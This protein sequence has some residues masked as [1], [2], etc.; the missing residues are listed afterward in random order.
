MVQLALQLDGVARRRAHI[1]ASPLGEEEL[2][3]L[4]EEN[5]EESGR[6]VAAGESLPWNGGV[7]AINNLIRL[8]ALRY[9]YRVLSRAIAEMASR[10]FGDQFPADVIGVERD[11]AIGSG[12]KNRHNFLIRAAAD[13][14]DHPR[15]IFVDVVELQLKHHFFGADFATNI[16]FELDGFAQLRPQQLISGAF[17]LQSF[18]QIRHTSGPL[19][20][21]ESAGSGVVARKAPAA[22]SGLRLIN[23]FDQLRTRRCFA[24][25]PVSRREIT[26]GRIRFA[27]V[28]DGGR[29]EVQID[30][31]QLTVELTAELSGH[32]GQN[33]LL[34]LAFALA[35][36]PQP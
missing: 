24:P 1:M 34:S 18:P 33:A 13:R 21:L 23:L 14:N 27:V 26:L 15:Q 19:A 22:L 25:A 32:R 3:G 16:H 29:L 7:R 35:H 17:L 20:W 8:A 5:F 11:D 10:Q 36:L 9:G 12:A 30:G 2:V 28:G 31:G 4:I 6:H